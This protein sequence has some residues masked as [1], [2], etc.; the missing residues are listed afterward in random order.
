MS[1]PMEKRPSGSGPVC[2]SA[3][4]APSLCHRKAS[5]PERLAAAFAQ[6]HKM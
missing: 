3:A 1:L 6:L 5:A 2:F 4:S